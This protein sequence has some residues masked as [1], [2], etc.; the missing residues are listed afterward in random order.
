MKGPEQILGTER[1]RREA[2]VTRQ[3]Q[4]SLR[5]AQELSRARA[6][7]ARVMAEE[8]RLTVAKEIG[9]TVATLTALLERME[10]LE[11][12]RRTPWSAGRL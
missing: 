8:G 4:E 10:A 1:V 6:E 12:M 7:Q 11:R 3:T 2:E 9:G 5:Q